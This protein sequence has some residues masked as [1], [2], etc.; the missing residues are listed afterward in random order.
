MVYLT[1][2]AAPEA[3]AGSR[4]ASLLAPPRVGAAAAPWW[5]AGIGAQI[6]WCA[7]FREP[8]GVP[9]LLVSSACLG[10]TAVLLGG[11]HAALCALAAEG[12]LNLPTSALVR[13]P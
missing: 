1:G 2:L 13:L 10:L 9:G 7:T 6:G 12:A 8:F 3:T 4:W 5:C 11:A